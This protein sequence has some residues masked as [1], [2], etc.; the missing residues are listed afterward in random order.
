MRTLTHSLIVLAFLAGTALAAP[1]DNPQVEANTITIPVIIGAI[2]FINVTISVPVMNND[3]DKSGDDN[4]PEQKTMTEVR[5][6][7]RT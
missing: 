3:S 5:D 1:V 7:F 4:R 6:L 2:P